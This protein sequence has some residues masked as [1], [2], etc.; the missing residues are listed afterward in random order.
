LQQPLAIGGILAEAQPLQLF[1]Q[2][3]VF[4]SKGFDGIG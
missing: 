4:P 1:T 3:I 2:E